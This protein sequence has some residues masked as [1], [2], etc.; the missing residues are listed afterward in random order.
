MKPPSAHTLRHVKSTGYSLNSHY[1]G[2]RKSSIPQKSPLN[3]STFAEADGLRELMA[4]KAA[5]S[6]AKQ[7]LTPIN[8]NQVNFSGGREPMVNSLS[9]M[10]HNNVTAP[11]VSH[12]AQVQSPPVTPF[13]PDFFMQTSAMMPPS[14]QAQYASFTDH[15]PPYSA[16]P[17]TNSSWSDA[18][19]TSP[20]VANFPQ[21]FIPSLSYSGP[22]DDQ[23]NIPWMFSADQSPGYNVNTTNENKKTEFYIQEFPNQKEEHAQAAR[24]LEGP[25]PKHYAFENRGQQD[26]A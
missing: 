5:E 21:S 14:L 12:G 8:T 25:R 15:T 7:L 20:D 26:Y 6:S 24:L 16:G 23:N 9:Q 1:S 2:I 4:Q 18:P 13:Q 11:E 19:L 22:G 3:V 17:L 10:V